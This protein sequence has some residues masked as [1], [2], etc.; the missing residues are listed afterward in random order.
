MFHMSNDSGLFQDAGGAGGG[1]ASG[2]TA[3][4][5]PGRSGRAT[6]PSMKP[7]S[8]TST[9]TGSR[10]STDVS[11]ADRRKGADAQARSTSTVPRRTRRSVV[12]P[13]YWVPETVVALTRLGLDKLTKLHN[14][15]GGGPGS[16]GRSIIHANWR[17]SL[18]S[19]SPQH[20]AR[21]PT[22]EPPWRRDD[23]RKSVLSRFR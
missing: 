14:A 20:H 16:A 7:S 18:A 15:A 9:T 19:R 23:S 13:R 11:R 1:R 6:C 3:T 8:F 5:F 22:S 2:W 17:R 12:L 4:F 21:Q 10:R